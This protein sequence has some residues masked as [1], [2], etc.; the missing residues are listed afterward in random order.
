RQSRHAGRRR[1]ARG[2]AAAQAQQQAGTAMLAQA[3]QAPQSV[4]SLLQG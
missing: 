4:L 2:G 1:R 3:K